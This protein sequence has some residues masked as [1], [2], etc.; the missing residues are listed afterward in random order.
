MRHIRDA[1]LL[2]RLAHELAV[3]GADHRGIERAFEFLCV[4]LLGEVAPGDLAALLGN[5][6]GFA[7]LEHEREPGGIAL[8]APPR[9]EERIPA[10][11]G[12]DEHRPAAAVGES[13]ADDLGPDPRVDIGMLVQHNAVQIKPAQRIRVVGAEQSHLRAARIIRAQL[14]LMDARSGL[15]ARRNGGAQ[16]IPR[17]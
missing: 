12:A 1:F 13:R 7:C 16:I 15:P 6:P 11:R 14:A 5:Q 4:L 3:I 10:L 17:D 9:L 8:R 2:L